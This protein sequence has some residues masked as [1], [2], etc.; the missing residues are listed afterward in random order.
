MVIK[1]RGGESIPTQ[2]QKLSGH[3]VAQSVKGL[4]LDFA[5]GH[6]PRALGFGIGLH[7]QPGACSRMLVSLFPSPCLCVYT[8]SLLL[9]LSL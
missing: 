8:L 5:S 4:A 9:S 7:A 2:T 3:R 1:H 6:D